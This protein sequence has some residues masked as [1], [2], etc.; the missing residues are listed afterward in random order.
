MP[1]LSGERKKFRELM[2]SKGLWDEYSA[3]RQELLSLGKSAAD[4][5]SEA[6]QRFQTMTATI[7]EGGPRMAMYAGRKPPT[8][9]KVVQWV[10][11]NM[12]VEDVLPNEAPSPGA[13]SLRQECRERGFR[14]DF[15][16]TIWP[17]LLP[18][19]SQIEDG[20]KAKKDADAVIE[21]I[22]RVQMAAAKAKHTDTLSDMGLL[23]EA[24]EGK[25]K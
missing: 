13:W 6:M 5:E 2:E 16:R 23:T 11:D 4:A 12:D 20:T 21:N 14:S 22:G 24:E 19:R 9:Q 1:R 18:T 17:K 10:F 15:Y 3:Y 25:T 8:A 7:P